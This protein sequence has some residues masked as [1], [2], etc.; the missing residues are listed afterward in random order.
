MML[1][2][3]WLVL[4]LYVVIARGFTLIVF[5]LA[6]GRGASYRAE[7]RCRGPCI[8]SEPPWTCTDNRLLSWLV[9][10]L[11]FQIRH[12]LFPDICHP[13]SFVAW[14]RICAWSGAAIRRTYVSFGDVS[15]M[16]KALRIELKGHV[17][18]QW[19][20]LPMS[21]TPPAGDGVYA[22]ASFQVELPSAWFGRARSSS[23]MSGIVAG[24]LL[25]DTRGQVLG[26]RAANA[27]ASAADEFREQI[28]IVQHLEEQVASVI[29]VARSR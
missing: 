2:S 25:V 27:R 20:L 29:K 23:G 16:A 6:C 7:W 12:H 14:S 24:L 18:T 9:G 3:P 10:G 17:H 26:P 13:Y 11:S 4:G 5:Q 21:G 15:S 1:H 28:R 22:S 8:R 19:L